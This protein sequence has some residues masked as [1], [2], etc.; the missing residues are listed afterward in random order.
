MS[1]GIKTTTKEMLEEKGYKEGIIVSDTGVMMRVRNDFRPYR[2][3]FMLDRPWDIAQGNMDIRNAVYGPAHNIPYNAMI[4]AGMQL[5]GIPTM[6]TMLRGAIRDLKNSVYNETHKD[7]NITKFMWEDDGECINFLRI[8]KGDVLIHGKAELDG[9]EY[10]VQSIKE[11]LNSEKEDKYNYYIIDPLENNTLADGTKEREDEIF[12]TIEYGDGTYRIYAIIYNGKYFGA[13][14]T[15]EDG[16][17]KMWYR[18][19]SKKNDG[20]LF[21]FDSLT[22]CS[23]YALPYLLFNTVD[24]GE[25]EGL[26]G[27]KQNIPLINREVVICS[28]DSGCKVYSMPMVV[29][30]VTAEETRKFTGEED[31]I[32]AAFKHY[33]AIDKF[34]TEGEFGYIPVYKDGRDRAYYINAEYN[35]SV[36][37]YH[38][39]YGTCAAF[40]DVMGVGHEKIFNSETE[41]CAYTLYTNTPSNA[42]WDDKEFAEKATININ[43]SYTGNLYDKLLGVSHKDREAILDILDEDNTVNL[44]VHDRGTIPGYINVY[45][46][47]NKEKEALIREDLRNPLNNAYIEYGRIFR[48]C[49][50]INIKE[51]CE[52]KLKISILE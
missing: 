16:S 52:L 4:T 44:I 21:T 5:Q 31:Y 38:K 13:V 50:E 17:L 24:G 34:N 23:L 22:S 47:K 8:G 49:Q 10:K 20:E 26:D 3:K 35:S 15:C 36:K 28:G 11:L 27:Y 7:G 18:P 51:D 14:R 9:A 32:L 41:V 48:V 1:L 2:G 45:R 37:T 25:M 46:L 33:A 39:G 40:Y 30:E 6:G 12:D 42:N 43:F 29:R 19:V